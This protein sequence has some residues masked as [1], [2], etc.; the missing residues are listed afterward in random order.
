MYVSYV[1]FT[2]E[3]TVLSQGI[4]QLI[5]SKLIVW[6]LVIYTKGSHE[7]HPS[8]LLSFKTTTVMTEGSTGTR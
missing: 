7:R 6:C 2:R 8:A 3:A 5:G 1:S 4:L